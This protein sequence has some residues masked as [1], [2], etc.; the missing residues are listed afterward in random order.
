M[1]A[2]H[3]RHHRDKHMR[4]LRI[5]ARSSAF[6]RRQPTAP[7]ITLKRRTSP[8]LKSIVKLGH[9]TILPS[10]LSQWPLR[11]LRRRCDQDSAYARF[12]LRDFLA[13]G[14]GVSLAKSDDLRISDAGLFRHQ[15][16]TGMIRDNSAQKLSAANAVLRSHA[17]EAEQKDH[18]GACSDETVQSLRRKH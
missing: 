10:G 2:G 4:F 13:L 8:R 9:K 15:D 17:N 18:S 6:Q 11:P 5:R 14:F 12:H 1:A 3:R 7:L 16:R